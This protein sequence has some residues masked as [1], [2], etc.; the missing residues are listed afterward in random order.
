MILSE[1]YCALLVHIPTQIFNVISVGDHLTVRLELYGPRAVEK[2]TKSTV[3]STK[4]HFSCC[5]NL[6]SSGDEYV[7]CMEKIIGH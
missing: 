3:Q 2:S 7:V 1:I 5:Q 6:I 4:R